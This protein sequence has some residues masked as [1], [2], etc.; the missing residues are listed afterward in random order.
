MSQTIPGSFLG[1]SLI[2]QSLGSDHL[3]EIEFGTAAKKAHQEFPQCLFASP[4]LR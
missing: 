2:G 3:R 1:G 4:T